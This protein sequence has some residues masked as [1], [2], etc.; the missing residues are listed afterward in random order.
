MT[1]LYIFLSVQQDYGTSFVGCVD[2]YIVLLRQFLDYAH[3]ISWEVGPTCG[4]MDLR[5]CESDYID[6]VF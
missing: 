1:C 4:W 2:D 6:Q 5:K 3:A